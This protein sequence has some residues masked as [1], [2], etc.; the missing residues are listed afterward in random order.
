MLDVK[1]FK[2]K[3]G[4]SFLAYIEY[5]FTYKCADNATGGDMERAEEG[6]HRE[7]SFI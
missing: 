3:C 6:V 4:S 1:L 2:V 7:R 5:L